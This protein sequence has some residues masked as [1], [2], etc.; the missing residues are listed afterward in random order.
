[1]MATTTIRFTACGRTMAGTLKPTVTN[2]P[3]RLK[4]YSTVIDIDLGP[5]G[6]V[7]REAVDLLRRL[8]A[9]DTTPPWDVTLE[10]YQAHAREAR[11]I[12][13]RMGVTP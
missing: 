1:M 8:A 13:R 12:L 5:D 3:H 7:L 11:E 2:C 6:E 10:T 9:V 4:G